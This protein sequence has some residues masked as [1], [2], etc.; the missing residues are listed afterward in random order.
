MK[1]M[2]IR[3]AKTFVAVFLGSLSVMIP[4][5]DFSNSKSVII[6]LLVAVV[7]SLLTAIMNIPK[8]RKLLNN[9]GETPEHIVSDITEEMQKFLQDISERDE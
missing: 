6:T 9:Y 7:S 4:T 1:N 8:V 2:M 5:M 3:T